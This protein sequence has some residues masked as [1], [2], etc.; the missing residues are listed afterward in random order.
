MSD[1]AKDVKFSL[2]VV[3]NKQKTKVL[4]AEIDSDLADVLFSFLTLPLGNI[5]RI[6]KKH[7]R[8]EAPVFGSITTLY[9]GLSNL[10]SSYFWTEGGKQMLLNP[11]SSF[12]DEC[13]KLK[14]DIGDNQ[15][16]KYFTC[17]NLNCAYTR[18][19]NLG[20]YFDTVRCNCGKQLKKEIPVRNVSNA[21]DGEAFTI[22]T[23]NFIIS[24]DL[25]I[26]PNA[27]ASFRH[28]VNDVG[29]I[30]IDGTEMRN[31]TF[32]FNEIMDLLKHSLFSP[33]PLTNLVLKNQIKSEPSVSTHHIGK[34][35]TVNS[36][37]KLKL[38]F[39]KSTNKFL[40]AEAEESFVEFLFGFLVI[41]LGGVERLLGND[42]YLKNIN[43]LYRSAAYVIDAKYLRTH[44]KSRLFSPTIPYGYL[45]QNWIF[46]LT[47]EGAPKQYYSKNNTENEECLHNVYRAKKEMCT[48]KS[49]KGQLNYM[50]EPRMYMVKDDLTVTPLC[51]NMYLNTLN[52]LKVSYSDIDEMV[53]NIG[54]KEVIAVFKH[55]EGISFIDICINHWFKSLD[56]QQ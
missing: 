11:V 45:S 20:I 17:E 55:I 7:Y 16:I 54:L 14:L 51:M 25:Q 42:T 12:I 52:E 49:P 29:L 27:T 56:K 9:D 33:T 32:G 41:S 46:S 50:K 47:E 23:A 31:L 28:I 10:D 34:I 48:F 6:L 22:K 37:R 24:D 19:T 43:N 30:D 3:I 1:M 39:Q 2:K 44:K 18:S 13:L 40:F 35:A 15:P 38:I 21:V 8:D 36:V 4:F 26:L 53:L 5:V